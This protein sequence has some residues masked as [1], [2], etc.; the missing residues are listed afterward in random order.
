MIEIKHITIIGVGGG[1]SMLLPA[2]SPAYDL[3]L[4][5]GDD[6][7]DKN[8]TR[9]IFSE[10]GR[11]KATALA[12]FYNRGVKTIDASP[13]MVIGSEELKSDLIFCCVDN[14]LA[15]RAA[16]SICMT[17]SI[18]LILI[19]NED[20]DPQAFLCLPEFQFTERDPFTRWGLG[21]LKEGRQQTCAGM[22][23]I[24]DIPQL[25]QANHVSGGFGLTI[26]QSLLTCNNPE[27]Y[28]IEVTG[29]PWPEYKRVLDI[30]P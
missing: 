15:R 1:G 16:H 17:N 30:E 27:N 20:W 13:E 25:P 11:N 9:Q 22:E 18:P 28:L 6:F 8:I 23:V 19:A 3:T 14:N 10:T 29:C 7:E 26:M 5:D 24:E 12:E 4:H 2:L 21:D